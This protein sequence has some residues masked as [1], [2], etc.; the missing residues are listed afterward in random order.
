MSIHVPCMSICT[1]IFKKSCLW[2][3]LSLVFHQ[4]SSCK[5]LKPNH[6]HCDSNLCLIRIHPVSQANVFKQ[7]EVLLNVKYWP[8]KLCQSHSFLV[9]L[10]DVYRKYFLPFEFSLRR[11]THLAPNISSQ[12]CQAPWHPHIFLLS[13]SH[14]SENLYSNYQSSGLHTLYVYL[15]VCIWVIWIWVLSATATSFLSPSIPQ[16]LIS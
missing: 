7:S 1:V 2:T 16:C 11:M 6:K 14:F 9:N 4:H 5:V 12:T 8:Q 10:S 13:C 3:S 15:C